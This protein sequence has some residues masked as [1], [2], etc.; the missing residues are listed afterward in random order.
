[1]LPRCCNHADELGELQSKAEDLDIALIDKKIDSMMPEL[2]F[3]PEDNDRLV[4]MLRAPTLCAAPAGPAAVLGLA[5]VV[6]CGC[7]CWR[8]LCGLRLPALTN[9]RLGQARAAR[10]AGFPLWGGVRR[11]RHSRPSAW[12][13]QVASFSGGWQMRMG[14]GKLLLKDPELLLLDEPT[15][16]LD[17]DAI[18][19]LEGERERAAGGGQGSSGQLGGRALDSSWGPGAGGG[20][21][22]A[23]GS[24]Q[25][26]G[27]R[28]LWSQPGACTADS[29]AASSP[30]HATSVSQAT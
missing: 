10:P 4:R 16:H 17:L 24:W 28:Q 30:T 27:R 3:S 22:L 12:R 29:Q 7:Y 20:G 15:N 1:M 9:S 5:G 21:N 18:E 14:L 11:R 25:R 23:S 13:M 8:L 26:A 6:A 2:G 19:W